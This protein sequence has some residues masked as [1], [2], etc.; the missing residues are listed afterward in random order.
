MSERTDRMLDSITPWEREDPEVIAVLEAGGGE[1]D[2]IE[3]M[4]TTVRDQA[5]PHQADDTYGLLA[6]HERTLGLPVAPDSPLA[7]RQT[8]VRVRFGRR[9]DGRKATWVDRVNDLLGG[10]SNWSYAENSPGVHQITVTLNLP[11]SSGVANQVVGLIQAFTPVVDEV[12]M[13]YA[14][15]FFI[16]ESAI[17]DVDL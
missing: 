16:G 15:T 11:V 4:M 9:R 6:V 3:Q 7:A 2:L 17:G 13:D 8:L 10:P 14:P 12:I 1:L 5:W